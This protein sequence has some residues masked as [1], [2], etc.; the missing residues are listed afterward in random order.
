MITILLIF[1]LALCI[2]FWYNHSQIKELAL[3]AGRDYCQRHHYQ[4]LDDTIVLKK[5]VFAWREGH[6]KRVFG[7]AYYDNKKEER[8]MIYIVMLGEAL[9]SIGYTTTGD[10][11]VSIKDYKSK[12]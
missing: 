11:V 1:A 10:N 7:M 6:M 12:E 4:L 3:S 5:L 2:Y 9:L 8:R